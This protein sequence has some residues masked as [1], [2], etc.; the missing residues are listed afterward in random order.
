MSSKVIKHIITIMYAVYFLMVGLGYNV[1]NY[2]CNQCADEGIE[3]VAISSCSEVHQQNHKSC[4][5]EEKEEES[6][7]LTCHNT[8]HL[9][10]SCH[11]LRLNIDIP[12]LETNDICYQFDGFDYFY[13]TFTFF[14]AFPFRDTPLFNHP[15]E[16]RFQL[17]GRDILAQNAVLLI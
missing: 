3:M 15:P 5:E 13:P 4:C 14:Q 12:S 7:D 6:N 11:L 10:S 2:C 8:N 9:P 1:V 16:N 17:S